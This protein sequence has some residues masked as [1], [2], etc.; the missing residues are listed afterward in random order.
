MT[1]QMLGVHLPHTVPMNDEQYRAHR[2]LAR[3]EKRLVYLIVWDHKPEKIER[4]QQIVKRHATAWKRAC[5]KVG[6]R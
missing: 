6:Q 4:Q 2:A 1:T 3:A 5:A